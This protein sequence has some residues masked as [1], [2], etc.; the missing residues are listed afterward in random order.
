MK[1]WLDFYSLLVYFLYEIHVR[2]GSMNIEMCRWKSIS[3]QNMQSLIGCMILVKIIFHQIFNS[4]TLVLF[5]ANSW[6][7]VMLMN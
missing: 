7:L 1:L 2:L 4:F 5:N 6:S 3:N